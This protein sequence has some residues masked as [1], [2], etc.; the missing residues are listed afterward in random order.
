MR[1]VFLDRDGVLNQVPVRDGRPYP[2]EGVENLKLFPE[3]PDALARLK[4]AGFLL[5]VVTNQPDVARGKQSLATVRQMNQLLADKLG[6][7]ACEACVHD[8]R[9]GCACR[10]PAPGM[11]T[12]A[13]A[14]L[15]LDLAS[16][17]MVGD[18]WRDILAGE[19]A[20]CHTILVDHRY[21]QE[22]VI[23]A[24]FV[25]ESLVEASDWILSRQRQEVS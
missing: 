19:R 22:P 8:D 10:K 18:R 15:G 6:L 21:P 11:I 9:D 13:A 23:P 12:A 5:I 20:G 24:E 1:A 7:H 25:C 17:F 16:S 14:K 3:V 4:R 2:P